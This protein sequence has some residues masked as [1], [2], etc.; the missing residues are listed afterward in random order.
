M[1]IGSY[2]YDA[3]TAPT[4]FYSEDV[5]AVSSG[6]MHH[7]LLRCDGSLWMWG[8]QLCGEFGN[9]STTASAQPIKIMDGVRQVCC[10]LQTTAIVKQ[11]GT[12]WMCGRNDMGQIDDTRTVHNTYKKIADNVSKVTLQWGC[13]GM[14]KTDGTTETRIW[15]VDAD[16]QR[17]PSTA[18]ISDVADVHYGWH[19]AIALK[20]DGSVW[21]WEGSNCPSEAIAGRNPQS[22]EGIR[23]LDEVLMKEK[24]T[25][26]VIAQRPVPLLADYKELKWR[27]NNEAVATV[28]ERGVVTTVGDGVANITATISD[29]YGREYAATCRVMAGEAQG[30]SPTTVTDW[31]LH[32][33]AANRQLVISGVP[34]GQTICVYSYA[35]ACLWQAC[36]PE[37]RLTIPV[38][39]GGIF[40]VQAARQ[41]KKVAVR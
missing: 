23:L 34:A 1:P 38:S 26:A 36:M 41:V 27:S 4:A 7:A 24:G 10:G 18:S 3:V 2:S 40:L 15:D 35:G 31:Q 33:T 37:G 22:L 21:A 30:I 16:S 39:Q 28:N 9:G 25:T 29:G 6:F 14:E 12:L 17:Q 32:V 13:I 19:C 20:Q 8:R 5:M 11:D